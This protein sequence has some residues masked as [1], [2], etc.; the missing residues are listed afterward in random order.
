MGKHV[1]LSYATAAFAGNCGALCQSALEAGFDQAIAMGPEDIRGS[2]FWRANSGILEQPRGA[3]YWLW[4]PYLIGEVLKTL[5]P[6]DVLVYCDA[7][8]S[9]YYRFRAF[10]HALVDLAL[11][12]GQGF[13]LGPALAQHGPLSRWT[14]RDCLI[15]M[16][17]D[18]PEFLRRPLI[19]A[20]W[21]I[22]TTRPGAMEFLAAWLS[23][24][25]DRRCLTDE[26][27]SLGTPNHAGFRDHRH[28][29]SILTLLAY[30]TGA[31]YLDFSGRLGV[32]LLSL[33]PRSQLAHLFLKRIGDCESL[34]SSRLSLLPLVRALAEMPR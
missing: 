33:R 26:A 4:K 10:P 18:R 1:F 22:W 3:G 24:C 15:L 14:K 30:R 5:S 8:R 19:Q 27:N 9:G 21:S 31:P 32:K 20:T 11:R 25:L 29:Q 7:G 12:S 34:A 23:F 17:S 28:D 16:Q 2:D 13:L 6:G